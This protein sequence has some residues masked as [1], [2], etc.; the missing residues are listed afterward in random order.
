[1]MLAAALRKP[2]TTKKNMI[3]DLNNILVMPKLWRVLIQYGRQTSLKNVIETVLG[4]PSGTDK[5]PLCG[6]H[7]TQ[8]TVSERRM[9]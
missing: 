5:V 7:L 8:N 9:S 6:L 3:L 4:K 1:M 2:C